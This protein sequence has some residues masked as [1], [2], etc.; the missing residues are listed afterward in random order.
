MPEK[1]FILVIDQGTTR[2]KVVI[3]DKRAKVISRSYREVACY[4]PKP[5]WVEHNPQEIWNSCLAC[6]KETIQKSRIEKDD[7]SAIA[8]TNQRETVLVWDRAS[9]EPLGNAIVWQCRRTA[10]FCNDLKRR[11]WE[12]FI[13]GKTGLLLDAYFSASKIRWILDNQPE[14]R[15]KAEKGEVICGTIDSWL[16]WKLTG[17]KIHLTD[18]T[19][20]SRTMLFNIHKLTWDSELLE[21][22]KIPASML[23]SVKASGEIYGYTASHSPLNSGIPIAAVLGDQQA[24][25]FGQACFDAGMLKNT[26]GTGCFLLLNT[27]E[28]LVS[29]EKLLTTIACD[30]SGKLTYAL[31]GSVFIAGA[32]VQWLR[33]GLGLIKEEKDTEEAARKIEDTEGVYLVPAFTGLGAPYWDPLARG[34]ILGINRGTR[35]EQIIRAALESIAYQV[36]DVIETME[37]EAKIKVEKLRVDGGAAENNWLMQ[38]Q[39]DILGIPVERPTISETTSLGAALLAGLTISFWKEQ[40]ELPALWKR[41]ALFLPQIDEKKREN[42]YQ[43][44]KKAVSRVLSKSL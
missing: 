4:Y 3:Y 22:F 25:L 27:G 30:G 41:D 15:R 31:E 16:I 21:L 9:G 11:G 13:R 8:I 24:A 5:G 43:G 39:A 12:D 23:P 28:K 17:G 19:N 6:I 33:D 14:I 37:K 20:A 38:F 44:W 36:R 42:L 7:I 2:T 34:A 29:S 26:Y 40:R 35:K 1:K 10:S 32:A 18:Y